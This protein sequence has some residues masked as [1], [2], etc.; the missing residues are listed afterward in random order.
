MMKLKSEG[1]LYWARI[2]LREKQPISGD[3]CVDIKIR[4]DSV[5]IESYEDVYAVSISNGS[6]DTANTVI[7]SCE[8]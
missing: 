6:T 8:D 5:Y 7:L 4:E 3:L 1:E 2:D